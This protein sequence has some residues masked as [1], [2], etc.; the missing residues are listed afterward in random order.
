MQNRLSN[1]DYV[2]LFVVKFS[3]A[4]VRTSIKWYDTPSKSVIR[5]LYFHC[6]KAIKVSGRVN[7]FRF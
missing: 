2:R 3:Q 4:V 6:L 1:L 7:N 5:A